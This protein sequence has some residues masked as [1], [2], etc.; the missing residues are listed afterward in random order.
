MRDA[1]IGADTF[2][3]IDF[4]TADS[5][6]DSAC[7]VGVV[8]VEKGRIVHR[9]ERF[10]RPPRP[11]FEFTYI[12]GITWERVAREPAFR[13]LWPKLRP[14][15]AGAEFL[16]AH[17]A[18]FDRS[19]LTACCDR[20]RLAVPRLPFECTVKIARRLWRIRPTRLPDV[21]HYLNIPLKHHDALS[22]AEAC[23][24]I[25]LA[26]QSEATVAARA[27]AV[28]PSRAARAASS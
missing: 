1:W 5:G 26:A 10:I 8:R 7:A 4:E 25:V 14:V 27:A 16:A 24:R 22:D 2:V 6:R 21:C 17:Q 28:G 15:M 9:E 13:E 20:G 12:H 18:S 19:V 11:Y 3:A 23:A